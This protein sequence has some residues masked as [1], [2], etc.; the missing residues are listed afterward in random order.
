M[1]YTQSSLL[2]PQKLRKIEDSPGKE[3]RFSICFIIIIHLFSP[4]KLAFYLHLR[5]LKT[6]RLIQYI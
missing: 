3:N 2:L 5:L 6:L 4:F 1:Y